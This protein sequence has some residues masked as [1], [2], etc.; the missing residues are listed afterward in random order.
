MDCINKSL[1]GK[2]KYKL[3]NRKNTSIFIGLLIF[4]FLIF[5]QTVQ[6]DCSNAIPIC[7]DSGSNGT[8][9]GFGVDDFNGASVSGCLGPGGG[10]SGTVES[11]SAWYT[12]TAA[13]DGQFGFDIIPINLSEDWDFGLYGPFEETTGNCG[14]IST[15]P[16]VRCNYS[17]ASGQTGI[18][19]G[20]SAYSPWLDVIAGETYILMINNFSNT[21][22]GFVLSFAGDV[23]NDPTT[24]GLD[25]SVVNTDSYCDGEEINLDATTPNASYY[26]WSENGD[27][28]AETGPILSGILA[29]E[30]EYNVEVFDANNT[31]INEESFI[32]GVISVN[33]GI[34]DNIDLCS[35]EAPLDLFTILGGNPD[36]GG[37]WSPILT[38]GT[39]VF[40][41]EVDVLGAYT[42]TVESGDCIDEAI[43][44]V[45]VETRV[46]AGANA[47]VEYCS[48]GTPVDLFDELGGTPATGGVW[49]P[50]LTSGTGV[51]D[52]STDISGTYTY[53]LPG[54]SICPETS[55]FVDVTVTVSPDAGED[56]LVLI[57]STGTPIDLF[58]ELLGTPDS[59][60]TWSPTL[61]SGTGIFDPM[62]DSAG[63]YTYTI[64]N[65]D[66]SDESIIDVTIENRPDAGTNG[67]IEFCSNEVPFDLFDALEG[68]P[69]TGGVWTPTLSS[70][71]GIFDPSID[72]QGDYTYTLQGTSI[73]P[74]SSSIVSVLVD[75]EPNAGEDNSISLCKTDAAID[76][77]TVLNGTPDT[78]GVWTPELIAGDGIFDPAIENA[79]DYTYTVSTAG[80]CA[81]VSA[82]VSISLSEAPI[83]TNIDIQDFS[84]NNIL[85]IEVEGIVSETPFGIGDYV[86]SYDGVNF[87][88]DN[89]FENVPPGTYDIIVR[90][91]NG[92]QFDAIQRN[93]MIVGAPRFFT[94]NN[95][96]RNDTWHIINAEKFPNAMIHIYDRFGKI[97]TKLYPNSDGWN[98]YYNGHKMPSGDYWYNFVATDAEGNLVSRKGH[99]SLISREY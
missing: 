45:N 65:G 48:T 78:G 62:T 91:L 59:G 19:I 17:G 83:I 68:T 98:G 67:T 40:D 11:N 81:E 70:G 58:S 82:V 56:N 66:C 86:Y 3:F 29:T 39:G 22:T 15:Q 1:E 14:N 41:P 9:G 33:A 18:G 4:P 38:S 52:P 79:G 23:I 24:D 85:T 13:A 10:P 80:K 73:C 28:L 25:C 95:D 75:V 61:T 92:C 84:E 16:P 64:V 12:F 47:I 90:D 2:K 35:S 74:G 8:V 94:P 6:S 42:Y 32:I 97:M 46:D 54:T 5:A 72:L 31:S 63:I 93:V 51:F 50:T 49:S 44:N 60:G 69:E 20:G 34:G 36:T 99:F 37:T 76:L 27:V 7:N 77:F 55:S 87:E 53:T 57:C 88:S 43:V 71:T 21:N 26:V 96:S 30:T 89:V